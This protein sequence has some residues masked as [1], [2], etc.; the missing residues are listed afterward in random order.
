MAFNFRTRKFSNWNTYFLQRKYSSIRHREKYALAIRITSSFDLIYMRKVGFAF[1]SLVE[2]RGFDLSFPLVVQL[3][4]RNP[5]GAKEKLSFGCK[6]YDIALLE[7]IQFK[8]HLVIVITSVHNK[9][10]SSK[11]LT[12]SFYG[13]KGNV[14]DRS[15]IL[16]LR[17]MDL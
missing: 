3:C 11:Q 15:K 14:I 1:F 9:G 5:F 13:R 16:F 4:S 7:F 17:R 6:A 12:S 8:E 10:G 2:Y